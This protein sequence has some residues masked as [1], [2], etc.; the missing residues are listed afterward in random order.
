MRCLSATTCAQ[1]NGKI[2]KGKT[3]VCKSNSLAERRRAKKRQ[4]R[5]HT[6]AKKR[7]TE[8]EQPLAQLTKTNKGSG[9]NE[10]KVLKK[11]KPNRRKQTKKRQRIL[12]TH[13][14][15]KA[16]RPKGKRLPAQLTNKNPLFRKR[17]ARRTDCPKPASQQKR[18]SR[19]LPFSSSVFCT[20]HK[21]H[22]C[23]QRSKSAKDFTQCPRRSFERQIP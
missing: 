18:E 11:Q 7:P 3:D 9:K 17:S 1:D 5:G 8:G 2:T 21:R 16:V 13:A 19:S 20:S 23:R 22:A 15:G 4:N 14:T 12:P 6:Y 10:K